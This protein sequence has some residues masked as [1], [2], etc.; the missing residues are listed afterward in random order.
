[1][2][3]TYQ[4]KSHFRDDHEKIRVC[5][6]TLEHVRKIGKELFSCWQCARSVNDNCK[7][8]ETRTLQKCT[9][10]LERLILWELNCTY[11]YIIS[12]LYSRATPP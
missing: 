3:K 6:N 7:G 2:L 8:T 1:M 4:F 9:A 5:G 10:L 11:A 12:F